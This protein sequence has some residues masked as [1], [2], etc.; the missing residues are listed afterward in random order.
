[1]LCL[2][3]GRLFIMDAADVIHLTG[4]L[5]TELRARKA[6]LEQAKALVPDDQAIITRILEDLGLARVNIRPL[7]ARWGKP[8][9]KRAPR[10]AAPS[11][12]AEGIR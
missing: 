9:R 7:L 11:T 10:P 6:A 4:L 8:K 1:M 3:G 2:A 5:T 12:K